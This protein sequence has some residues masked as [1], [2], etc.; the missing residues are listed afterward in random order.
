MVSGYDEK[1]GIDDTII[2]FR[3]FRMVASE[4]RVMS[5]AMEAK[6]AMIVHQSRISRELVKEKALK[7]SRISRAEHLQSKV[8]V[9]RFSY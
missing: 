1:K 2:M 3:Y 8:K 4:E 5:I 9:D 6:T 7:V